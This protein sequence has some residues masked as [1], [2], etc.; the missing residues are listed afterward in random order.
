MTV[1]A[2]PSDASSCFY[3]PQILINNIGFHLSKKYD[4]VAS[5]F[6]ILSL[7]S[8]KLLLN[9]FPLNRCDFVRLTA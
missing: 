3:S 4:T 7:N 9:S 8:D 1:G 2:C 6:F 5:F